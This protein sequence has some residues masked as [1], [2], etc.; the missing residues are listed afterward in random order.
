MTLWDVAVIG[1][2]PAGCSAAI[3]LAGQGLRVV[4]LEAKT[5]PHDKLCGEFLS[6]ECAGLLFGLGMSERITA[7]GPVE[8]HQVCL[9]APDGAAWESRLPGVALGIS[10]KLLDQALAERVQE[11]GGMVQ[12]ASPVTGISGDLVGGF[13]LTISGKQKNS[14]IRARAVVAAYGKRAAIDRV[15]QRRFLQQRQ[16]FVAIKAHFHGPPIP[17]RIELHAFPG[18]YCGLSEIE[19][20]KKV[21]CLL[22]HESVFR[23]ARSPDG[24]IDWI[25]GQNLA[26]HAWLQWAERIHQRWIS[27]AQVPFMPKPAMERDVL[28]AGDSAGLIVPLAGDGIAMALEGGQ[29]AAGFLLRLFRGEISAVAL[30]KEYP[31]AWNRRFGSRLRL[32]RALQPL[33]LYSRA[34]SAALRLLNSF[35]G[36]GKFL[37]VRTRGA[38]DRKPEELGPPMAWAAGKGENGNEMRRIERG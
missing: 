37:I 35:P 6:P 31:R 23:K 16:P 5:Y 9:T 15:L 25:Q 13:I 22:A 21:V 29:L 28:M 8:I 3:S 36:L 7:L 12:E 24:F 10:R 34:T 17:G 1:G 30:R 2:G 32:G 11:L 4:L 14:E 19:D 27:I 38:V 18:G 33:M 20:G 26:L